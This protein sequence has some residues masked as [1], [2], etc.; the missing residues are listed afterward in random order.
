MDN[1]I[2]NVMPASKVIIYM[3]IVAEII[4]LLI[5]I[6][7]QLIENAINVQQNV[8]VALQIQFAH[9]VLMDIMIQIQ[10]FPL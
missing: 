8:A 1:K 6:R 5:S 9:L 10:I 2:Q 4:V 7:I 3:I